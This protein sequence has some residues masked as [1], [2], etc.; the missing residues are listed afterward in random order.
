MNLKQL[1]RSDYHDCTY[2]LVITHANETSKL[3]SGAS[4]A[5]LC[6]CCFLKQDGCAVLASL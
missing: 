3:I 6:N 5:S 2:M 4:V 1:P